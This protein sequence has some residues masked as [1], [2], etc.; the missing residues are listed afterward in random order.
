MI[1]HQPNASPR[2]MGALP[3]KILIATDT[4]FRYFEDNDY[5]THSCGCPS[6]TPSE[7]WSEVEVE[8]LPEEAARCKV[9]LCSGLPCVAPYCAPNG[10]RVVSNGVR[11]RGVRSVAHALKMPAL[12]LLWACGHSR[13][14]E[15]STVAY[16]VWVLFPIC[17]RPCAPISRPA[18]RREAGS[19]AC[20]GLGYVAVPA[21]LL[22]WPRRGIRGYIRSAR[23][24][25]EKSLA[26]VQFI[27]WI[28]LKG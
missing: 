3:M 11:N 7:L 10:I 22:R 2:T 18:D 17:T 12:N 4:V 25:W 9:F 16:L 6:G 1:M 19:G 8:K 5:V 13:L 20:V 14:G 15:R 28:G 24:D 21:A 23:L 26:Y 27:A